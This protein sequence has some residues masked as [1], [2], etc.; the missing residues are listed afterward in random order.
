MNIETSRPREI[1]MLSSIR[2][3]QSSPNAFIKRRA[4]PSPAL[5]FVAKGK[6]R[7]QLNERFWAAEPR[8]LYYVPAGT[9]IEATALGAPLEY[10]ILFVQ[11]A[12]LLKRSGRKV[13]E[14]LTAIRH[15]PVAGPVTGC[16]AAEISRRILHLYEQST[17]RVTEAGKL[18]WL[19]Q[20]LLY[21]IAACNIAPA[22]H[23]A[24]SRGIEQSI[25]YM[26]DHYNEKI[27]RDTLA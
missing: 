14:A 13:I 25:A 19:L 18:D 9:Q 21:Y 24:N 16:D 11:A 26:E 12:S 6:A 1:Y 22:D 10:Y 15:L 2:R 5:I 20:E 17:Q 23:H 4:L 7:L 3:R 8:Q 27:S